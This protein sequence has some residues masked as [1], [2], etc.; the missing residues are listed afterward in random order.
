[1]DLEGTVL[2]SCEG[3]KDCQDYR[4]LVTFTLESGIQVVSGIYKAQIS[5]FVSGGYQVDAYPAYLSIEP[6]LT[7]PWMPS[8]LPTIP[9]IRLAL[10]DSAQGEVNLLDDFEF[11][12]TE[13][14]AAMRWVVDRWNNTPPPV[15]MYSYAN[16]P[17]RYWWI[18]G[19]MIQLLNIAVKRY[20][21]N[22]LPY[23]AGGVTIDDQNK[24]A[25]YQ[26]IADREFKE[27]EE[28]FK[29]EKRRQNYGRAWSSNRLGS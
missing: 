9:E 18:R 14:A 21:R 24:A 8:G 10:G 29:M 27:F 2:T 16:F 15:C 1:M 7:N 28:W 11:E 17:Y 4:G 13:I 22:R 19:T 25:E 26:G 6:N 3:I 12:D 23:Q 20:A 5:R